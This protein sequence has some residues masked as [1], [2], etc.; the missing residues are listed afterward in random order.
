MTRVSREIREGVLLTEGL[1]IAST[2][3]GIG[4]TVVTTGLAGAIAGAGLRVQAIKPLEFTRGT[5][6]RQPDQAFMDHLLRPMQVSEIITAPTAYEVSNVEWS[7]ILHICRSLAYPVL[8]EMPG[9]GWLHPFPYK[10]LLSGMLRLWR[11]N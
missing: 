11:G 7:R 6:K 8:I 9:G 2:H 1:I 4:K 5:R 10:M 3:S